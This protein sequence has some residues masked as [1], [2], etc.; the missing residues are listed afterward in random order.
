MSTLQRRLVFAS[1]A[2]I[3]GLLVLSACA[4]GPGSSPAPTS[5]GA[6]VGA[7]IEAARP[8]LPDGRVIATGTVMDVAGDVQLCLGAVAESYPPQCTGI[9][10]D[11]WTWDG[12]DG[13]ET[14]G[15]TTWGTY[16]VYGTY[17]GER[18]TNTD[19]PIMLALFDP[20]APADPTDGVDG[21]TDAAELASVQDDVTSRLG[22]DALTVSTERGYVWVQVVWDDGTIQDAADAQYGDDVVV[23][24]SAL[25]EID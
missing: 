5:T 4:A 12:V 7:G 1:A 15:D 14:S 16:A 10:L 20:I 18:Y 24:S 8:G 23:V 21:T 3:V 17:D 2:S 22:N 25:R 19:P 6:P 9:P 11:A 13:S